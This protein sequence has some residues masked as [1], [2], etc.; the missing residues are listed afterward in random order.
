MPENED[1]GSNFRLRNV[2]QHRHQR[3]N[4]N[5]STLDK[6]IHNQNNKRPLK[7]KLGIDSICKVNVPSVSRALQ[8]DS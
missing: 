3:G 8:F 1:N 2:A 6:F 5:F 7:S 4:S